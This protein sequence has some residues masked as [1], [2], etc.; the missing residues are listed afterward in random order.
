VCISMSFTYLSLENPPYY[1]ADAS[2]THVGTFM[3]Q[4]P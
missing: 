3:P 1:A 2:F 4:L